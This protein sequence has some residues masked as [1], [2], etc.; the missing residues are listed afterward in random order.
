MLV[1]FLR[2]TQIAGTAYDASSGEVDVDVDIADELVR[3]GN[4]VIVGPGDDHYVTAN[5]D[6]VTGGI[7]SFSVGGATVPSVIVPTPSASA[8]T[9]YNN[10]MQAI[11]D[12]GVGG[13]VSFPYGNEWTLYREIT[14]LSGQI[15][16]FNGSKLK[17]G[18]QVY[19]ALTA[20]ASLDSTAGANPLVAFSVTSS[21]GFFVGMSVQID[22]QTVAGHKKYT[23]VPGVVTYVGTGAVTVQFTVALNG[24]PMVD[25]TTATNAEANGQTWTIPVGA[26]LCSISNL[27]YAPY[28]SSRVQILD[29]EITGNAS[30]NALANRWETG[31]AVHIEGPLSSLKNI[32]VN[33]CVADAIEMNAPRCLADSVWIDKAN[34]AGFHVGAN[35]DSPST[36]LQKSVLTNM[37]IDSPGMGTAQIGHYGGIT[38]DYPAYAGLMCSQN[39]FDIV[40]SNFVIQNTYSSTLCQGIGHINSGSAYD[41]RIRFADGHIVDQ[42]R[43]AFQIGGT[44]T[45]GTEIDIEGITVNNC[46]P[47]DLTQTW[48]TGAGSDP[49]YH[50]YI[51]D[52]TNSGG[53]RAELVRVRNCRF[54]N[55][56]LGIEYATNVS[57]ENTHFT[58]TAVGKSSS[59]YVIG[60]GANAYTVNLSN[61]SSSRVV[62]DGTGA[63]AASQFKY[64]Y[65]LS[66]SRVRGNNVKSYGGTYTQVLNGADVQI[67][68]F[69]SEDAYNCGIQARDSGTKLHLE[70]PWIRVN[71]GTTVSTSYS[72]IVTNNSAGE[73]VIVNPDI[74]LVTTNAG[75]SGIALSDST[76]AGTVSVVQGGVVKVSGTSTTPIK[77]GGATAKNVVA[78]TLLSHTFTPGAAETASGTVVSANI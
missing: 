58:A 9:N 17:L 8:L 64:N 6:A 74:N 29:L 47:A 69:A 73:T 77:S 7:K 51:G 1:R 76:V 56:P 46:T 52:T 72:G 4:A 24:Y 54:I 40:F 59:L 13:V 49:A 35:T 11:T 50:S 38:T 30:N 70:T 37:F 2:R 28:A 78:G 41:S 44:T 39:N 5:I 45:P 34:A 65:Y 33:T 62:G 57:V 26:N 36:G 61:V 42:A 32:Y 75:Q 25:C 66:A 43:G 20:T 22:D 18:D 68:N 10:I 55:S 3:A 23:R 21:V 53:Q 31:A 67:S 71:S 27:I 16:R 19:S 12:A 60:S 48:N 15:L 14:P 63:P